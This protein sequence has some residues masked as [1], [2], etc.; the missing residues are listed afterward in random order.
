MTEMGLAD[1]PKRLFITIHEIGAGP[2]MDMEVHEPRHEVAFF[3]IN[4]NL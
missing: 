2:S 4:E 1:Y 3:Q